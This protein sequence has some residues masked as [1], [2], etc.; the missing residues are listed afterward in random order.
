MR[1]P[2]PIEPNSKSQTSD[3]VSIR[4]KITNEC[5]GL[6]RPKGAPTCQDWSATSIFSRG[7][8]LELNIYDWNR[9][10]KKCAFRRW[11]RCMRRGHDTSDGGAGEACAADH[12]AFA[13]SDWHG[14]VLR[15]P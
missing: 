15:S 5:K 7:K 4:P 10:G 3:E 11:R 14:G 6:L 1:K 13:E 12:A 2:I 8:S 9:L